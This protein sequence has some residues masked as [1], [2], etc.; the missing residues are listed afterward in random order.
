MIENVGSCAMLKSAN[1]LNINVGDPTM[2][3]YSI[4]SSLF[5]DIVLKK[6]WKNIPAT[7]TASILPPSVNSK[8]FFML[9]F[10]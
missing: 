8:R 7:V 10:K 9:I 4:F 6:A 5:P 3:Y 1:N 2:Y